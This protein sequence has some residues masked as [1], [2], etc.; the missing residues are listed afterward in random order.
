LEKTNSKIY[1]E[2]SPENESDAVDSVSF[3][4]APSYQVELLSTEVK[5][6]TNDIQEIKEIF[7]NFTSLISFFFFLFQKIII[8]FI[9]LFKN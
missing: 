7:K 9:L 8:F 4:S 5:K 1:K 6:N 3:S 2:D